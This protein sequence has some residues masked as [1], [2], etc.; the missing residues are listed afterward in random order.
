[1]VSL[2]AASIFHSHVPDC[3]Q[4]GVREVSAGAVAVGSAAD[5]LAAKGAEGAEAGGAEGAAGASTGSDAEG[6]AG[7][8]AVG[9]TARVAANGSSVMGGG[10]LGSRCEGRYGRKP[11]HQ[12]G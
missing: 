11:Q 2:P 6:A 1:M 3:V 4:P 12:H 10:R 5:A 8:S 7:E 9:L